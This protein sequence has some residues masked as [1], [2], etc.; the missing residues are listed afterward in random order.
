MK[1]EYNY[2]SYVGIVIARQVVVQKSGLHLVK[3]LEKCLG[4]FG[5]HLTSVNTFPKSSFCKIN[6]SQIF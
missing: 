2:T 1:L 4:V 5:G 6:V 3:H